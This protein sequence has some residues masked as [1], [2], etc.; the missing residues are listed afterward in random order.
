MAK[1]LTQGKPQRQIIAF[2]VPM[3]IGNLFQQFYNIVDSIIVGK[4][5]G[6]N[7]L[8]AVSSSFTIMVF[9]T[10][11]IIGLCMGSGVVFSQFYGAKDFE[12]VKSAIIMSFLFILGLT[13]I[14]E[15]SVLWGIDGIIKF[16]NIPLSLCDLTKDYL[17]IIFS[18][19]IFVFL[20]NIMSSILR[21]LGDSKTPLYFLI[22][23]AI[24][25]VILDLCFVL[26]WDKGVEGVAIAT[27]IAQAISAILCALYSY[28]KLDVLHIRFSDI[29]FNRAIFKETSKYALLTCIQQ[30]IMNL[31]I[32]LVQ[33]LVNSFGAVAMAAFGVATKID[34]FAYMPVQDFGNAF[35]TYVAQNKGAGNEKRIKEGTRCAIKMICGF[36]IVISFCVVIFAKP[37]MTIF[38]KKEEIEVINMGVTY[39]RTVAPFYILIG[40]LF[41]YYG[42]YR[43]IGSAGMSIVLTIISLGTRVVLAYILASIPGIGIVG[44]WWAIPIGWA[45]A[46]SVGYLVYTNKVKIK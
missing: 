22:L 33:G 35:S 28:K 24:L 32:V 6:S 31:G 2:A 27:L 37:L 25:N 29:R 21:A 16:M 7:A 26:V 11:I 19:I 14:L 8:A 36:C 13:I 10:S 46:D 20:Y 41:M 4:F 45:L 38:I 12:K 3:I 1:D 42:L 5:I 44:I 15:T 17:G 9:I 43:A 18:G 23:S 40:F 30:S 34:A 39:L